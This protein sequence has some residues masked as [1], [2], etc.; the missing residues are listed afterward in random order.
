MWMC[1]IQ[2]YHCNVNS[3][4]RICHSVFDRNYTTDTS[5]GIILSCLYGLLLEPE[6]DDP[7]DRYVHSPIKWSSVLYLWVTQARG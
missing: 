7:L 6:P 3:S 4:G 1:D 5:I 2:I